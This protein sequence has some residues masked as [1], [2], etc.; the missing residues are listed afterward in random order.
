MIGISS[1]LL[2]ISSGISGSESLAGRLCPSQNDKGRSIFF[3]VFLFFIFSFQ[4]FTYS[5]IAQ[6]APVPKVTVSKKTAKD[7]DKIHEK[8]KKEMEKQTEDFQHKKKHGNIPK[9]KA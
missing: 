4:L 2:N 6:K 3:P 1:K 9:F 8:S 5:S 7:Q